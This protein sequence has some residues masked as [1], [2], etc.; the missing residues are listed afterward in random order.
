[1]ILN[2]DSVGL[3]GRNKNAISLEYDK[4][5]IITSDILKTNSNEETTSITLDSIEEEI[6]AISKS[7]YLYSTENNNDPQSI[8]YG[9]RLV[10]VLTWIIKR[11]KD[12]QHPPNNIPINTFFDKADYYIDN[13]DSYLLNK[14]IKTR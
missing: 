11:L 3:I 7:M 14:R 12:H 9:E 2:K 13:M 8:V 1:M 4:S 6:F 10:E 5:I